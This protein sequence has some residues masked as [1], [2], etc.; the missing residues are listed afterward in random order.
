MNMIPI[1]V[2][3]GDDARKMRRSLQNLFG[4]ARKYG[5]RDN[6]PLLRLS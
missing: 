5:R 1:T 6:Q 2:L 3:I 4:N